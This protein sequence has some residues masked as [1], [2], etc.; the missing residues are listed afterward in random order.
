MEGNLYSKYFSPFMEPEGS[1]PSTKE[2]ATDHYHEPHK[3][4]QHLG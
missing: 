3:S 4:I 1:L 2:P